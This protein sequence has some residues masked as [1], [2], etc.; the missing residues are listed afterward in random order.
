MT[1][2]FTVPCRLAGMNEYQQACRGHWAQGAKLK[3]QQQALVETAILVAGVK[4][5]TA[6]VTVQFRW[7]EPNRRR[8]F[9]NICAASKWV[10][11]AMV[12]RGVIPDDSDR[13]VKSVS[14]ERGL[15]RKAPR[16]EVTVTEVT[17]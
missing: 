10:L 17:T 12:A 2:T 6:P 4:P 9:D 5:F 7:V 13:W 11:D 3:K 15:D 16:V 1:Q 14:H 8:D